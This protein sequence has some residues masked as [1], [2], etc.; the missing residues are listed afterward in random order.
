MS[1]KSWEGVRVF[2]VV[3]ITASKAE[4]LTP[5]MGLIRK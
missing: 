2:V 3:L 1:E 5:L 4:P